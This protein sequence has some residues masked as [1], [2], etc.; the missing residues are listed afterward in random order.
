MSCDL[1]YEPETIMGTA[2]QAEGIARAKVL[3]LEGPKT[4]QL[5]PSRE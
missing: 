1:M 2:F 5:A 3:S 4:C